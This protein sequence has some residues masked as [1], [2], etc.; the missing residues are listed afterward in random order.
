VETATEREGSQILH[1]FTFHSV[2]MKRWKEDIHICKYSLY[3]YI[4]VC[5]RVYVYTHSHTHIYLHII[6][7]E[8][9]YTS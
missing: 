4:C 3:I 9:K 7:W 5:V 8:R 1:S 6:Q 2:E